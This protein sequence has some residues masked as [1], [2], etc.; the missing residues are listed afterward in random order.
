MSATGAAGRLAIMRVAILVVLG[1]LPALSG[2]ATRE[3]YN[4]QV[5]RTTNLQRLLAE[6]EKRSADLAAEIARLK[7]QVGD[8]EIQNKAL[9]TQLTDTRAQIVRSLEEVGRLQDE[10]QRARK[11]HPP[12]ESVRGRAAT[13]PAPMEPP[14][15]LGELS[16]E[17]PTGRRSKGG[18]APPEP[19]SPP[20]SIAPSKPFAGPAPVEPPDRLGE[21]QGGTTG[22]KKAGANASSADTDQAFRYHVVKKGETLSSIA[23]HYKTDM[24][25]LRELND[26]SG[27]DIRIGDRLIVGKKE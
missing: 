26:L 22:G 14:D 24:K 27:S 5:N 2:C 10:I 19:V 8:L 6:E 21:L 3:N 12:G 18:P 17:P 11:G 4:A 20:S 15:R 13:A 16:G 23:R 9:T 7:K 1:C 25:T